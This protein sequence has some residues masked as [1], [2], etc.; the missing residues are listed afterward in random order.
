MLAYMS[1]FQF[2]AFRGEITYCGTCI[3]GS[4]VLVLT[5]YNPRALIPMVEHA[6]GS[7][8]QKYQNWTFLSI[9]SWC[10]GM[11]LRTCTGENLAI[12]D[13]LVCGLWKF[14]KIIFLHRIIFHQDIFSVKLR[15]LLN[16]GYGITNCYVSEYQKMQKQDKMFHW[17]SALLTPTY[18][19]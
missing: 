8:S 9:R 12:T 13:L 11:E 2:S 18:S 14:C 3:N 15:Q 17:N 1:L 5:L 19:C 6:G 16:M 10:W 4:P 7:S